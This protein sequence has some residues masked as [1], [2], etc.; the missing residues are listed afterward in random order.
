[1]RYRDGLLIVAI[2]AL[3]GGQDAS[4]LTARDFIAEFACD[5]EILHQGEGRGASSPIM[6]QLWVTRDL[7]VRGRLA[8]IGPPLALPG[9]ELSGRMQVR[10]NSSGR[11]TGGEVHLE[12]PYVR[13]GR[14]LVLTMMRETHMALGPRFTR[15][16]GDQTYLSAKLRFATD[17]HPRLAGQKH[18][19][20]V[21]ATCLPRPDLPP[22]PV[23]GRPA[24][25]A[26]GPAAPPSQAPE[27]DEDYIG[28]VE[29]AAGTPEPE[30][31]EVEV[32]VQSAEISL[33][34]LPAQDD[35][36][37]AHFR[38]QIGAFKS[39]EAAATG[40]KS[41]SAR[42]PELL[43]EFRHSVATANLDDG[44]GI[45]HR[46]HVGALMSREKAAALC[47][48]LKTAGVDCFAFAPK[49]TGR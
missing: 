39:A 17:S 44:R 26:A 35:G 31:V 18:M 23:K 1:L 11:L 36:A 25:L 21:T 32:E 3:A 5:G 46:L 20:I 29:T 9:G 22:G 7:D 8:D 33:A 24:T 12:W 42:A 30:A 13:D 2:V 4:A 45:F 43:G 15:R 41:A 6:F 40:W 37:E 47:T 34:M 28:P 49:G 16:T 48:Q 19:S 38:V 27:V 14:P 10:Y